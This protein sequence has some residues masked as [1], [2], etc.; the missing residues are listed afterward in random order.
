MNLEN[1]NAIVASQLMRLCQSSIEK[2]NKGKALPAAGK[3]II[4]DLFKDKS[5]HHNFLILTQMRHDAK[6]RKEAGITKADRSKAEIMDNFFEE[7]MNLYEKGIHD[8]VASQL[9]KFHKSLEKKTNAG[10]HLSE[11]KKK[12]IEA[13]FKNKSIEDNLKKLTEL[14]DGWVD[15]IKKRNAI[16][17]NPYY[18]EIT[19]DFFNK[20][21]EVCTEVLREIT[22]IKRLEET[23]RRLVYNIY[24]CDKFLKEQKEFKKEAKEYDEKI[25]KLYEDT[26]ESNEKKKEIRSQQKEFDEKIKESDE[27]IQESHEKIQE[28][29]EKMKESDEKIKEI[30]SQQKESDEKLREIRSQRKE[31]GEKIKESDE[32]I[33]EIRIQQKES[34]DKIGGLESKQKELDEKIKESDEKIG[35]FESKQKEFDERLRKIDEKLKEFE[36]QQKELDMQLKEIS[37]MLKELESKQEELDKRHKEFDRKLQELCKE[38]HIE[39]KNVGENNDLKGEYNDFSD[40]HNQVHDEYNHL[41]GNF[42]DEWLQ[43]PIEVTC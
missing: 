4:E 26:K 11:Q 38:C 42:N 25:K 15:V 6:S 39:S 10:R 19:D 17:L 13:E 43:K 34:D 7:A 8:I 20:P 21:I 3:K 40:K 36:N 29:H 24:L 2:A 22:H 23:D 16:E 1:I 12:K 41:T 5:I 14:R 27:K 31:Y 18:A 28:S 37:E 30:R 33:K 32:K 35:E 9:I